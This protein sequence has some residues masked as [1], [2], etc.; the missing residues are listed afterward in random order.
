MGVLD[1]V[2]RTNV[3]QTLLSVSAF[4]EHVGNWELWITFREMLWR[5]LIDYFILRWAMS[6]IP[7]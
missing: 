3:V 2:D 7:S 5:R 6:L 4:K 1:C